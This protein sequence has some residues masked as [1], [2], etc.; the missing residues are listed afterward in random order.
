MMAFPRNV[1]FIDASIG[2]FNCF[3]FILTELLSFK[4]HKSR[5][6]ERQLHFSFMKLNQ[7]GEHCLDLLQAKL[8]QKS[9]NSLLKG[10]NVRDIFDKIFSCTQDSSITSNTNYVV[11]MSL[12]VQEIEYEARNVGMLFDDFDLSFLIQKVKVSFDNFRDHRDD[13]LKYFKNC[14][15]LNDFSDQQHPH[16]L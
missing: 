5:L 10:D 16:T 15:L 4:S 13:L 14:L 12:V 11:Y 7:L 1:Y 8:C 3:I 9:Q 6:L 2:Q